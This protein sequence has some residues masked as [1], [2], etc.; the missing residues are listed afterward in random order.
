MTALTSSSG[1]GVFPG[2][3]RQERYGISYLTDVCAEAGVGVLETRSGEDHYAIDAYVHL[4]RGMASVQ[5]KC[6]T[7]QFTQ[8]SPRHI[9]WPVEPAWW[10]KWCQ[11][12]AP[13]FVLLVQVPRGHAAWIDYTGQ[14]R[15]LHF[16][17]AYWV[18]VDKSLSTTP[19][20]LSLPR[21]Q[22]FTKD[23][24]TVWDRIHKKG[25]GLP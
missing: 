4:S 8:T 5:V 19:S 11:D 2:S 20:S 17:A 13:T 18:E 25:L 24:L 6:T 15:T 22:R 12:S 21:N 23:T 16:T 10:G 1:P 3:T 7:K 9:T 14:D